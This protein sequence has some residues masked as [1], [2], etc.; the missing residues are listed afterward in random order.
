MGSQPRYVVGDFNAVISPH[1]ASN[2]DVSASL[3][4]LEFKNVLD[5][6]C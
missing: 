4:M 5:Y 2:G 1:E 3:G 6:H